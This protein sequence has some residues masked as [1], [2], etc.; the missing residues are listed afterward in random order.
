[1]G[2]KKKS[3]L[4]IIVNFLKTIK[5]DEINKIKML[6]DENEI[7]KIQKCV[8]VRIYFVEMNFINLFSIKTRFIPAKICKCHGRVKY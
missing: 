1:M 2:G 7:K 3:K 6:K 4:L 5:V 8:H